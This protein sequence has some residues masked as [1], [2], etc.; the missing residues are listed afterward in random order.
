MS[1]ETLDVQTG[2]RGEVFRPNPISG[3][4]LLTHNPRLRE[5]LIHGLLRRG[6][7]GNVI[8]SPKIGK[9]WLVL[10]MGLAVAT[11]RPWL[12]HQVEQ[13]AV[14]H[15]DNE[16]HQETLSF[17][18]GKVAMA[19]GVD[20]TGLGTT[21]A[22]EPIRGRGVTLLDLP[23]YFEDVPAGKY[24]LVILDAFY[25]LMPRGFDENSNADMTSCYNVIEKLCM[26]LDCAFAI[27]HHASKGLQSSKAVTDVGAGAGA[28]SRCPDN[29]I[30]IRKHA[31]Q[32]IFVLAAAPRS[33]PPVDPV[34]VRRD[35]DTQR[36][37]QVEG[38]DPD[39]LEPERKSNAGCRKKSGRTPAEF[40]EAFV[41]LVPQKRVAIIQAAV[42]GG[43][44][45]KVADRLLSAAVEKRLIIS[46]GSA[47]S[48]TYR[49]KTP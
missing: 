23:G 18:L 10:D 37:E 46:E 49:R 34:C 21:Y 14:L 38:Y 36:W 15:I 4:D 6:E 43:I 25:R 45:E 13:G 19:R 12:G 2:A 22:L 44:P 20:L 48:T 1:L 40:V 3:I 27:V 32:G 31:E 28:Q 5:P 30:V 26:K 17:R 41:D 9:S 16:L 42:E 33:F 29:H 8:A 7:Y 47:R 39:D 35:P 24:R 11:G